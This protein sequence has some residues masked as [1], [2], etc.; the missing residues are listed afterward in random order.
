MTIKKEPRP[1]LTPSGHEV[2]LH[3]D[4]HEPELNEAEDDEEAHLFAHSRDHVD[5]ESR[6]RGVSNKDF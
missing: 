1:W 3:V 4:E 6:L 2:D 5:A